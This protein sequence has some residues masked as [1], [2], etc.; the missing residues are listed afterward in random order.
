MKVRKLLFS[1]GVAFAAL[2]LMAAPLGVLSGSAAAETT[3]GATVDWSDAQ[4]CTAPTAT[5]TVTSQ[6]SGAVTY[7]LLDGNTLADEVT[8]Q[9]G[10]QGELNFVPISGHAYN[11]TVVDEN[12]AQHG[13]ALSGTLD[14]AINL[15]VQ[16]L[17]DYDFNVVNP[18][19]FRVAIGYGWDSI[20]DGYVHH[21]LEPGETY[22][23]EREKP[24]GS[25][26]LVAYA[27]LDESTKTP[28]YATPDRKPCQV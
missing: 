15:Q 3:A 21:V 13:S 10:Q 2:G 25:Q 1:A 8:L 20:G 14:C 5:A 18:H 6:S 26:T 12:G 19:A 11:L 23:I 7:S 4:S 9:S 24:Q 22:F 28:L 16:P 27:W 17:C